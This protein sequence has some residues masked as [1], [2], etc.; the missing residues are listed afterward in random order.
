MIMSPD[1]FIEFGPRA[2]L[3]LIGVITIVGGVWQIDRTW[4]EEGSNAYQRAKARSKDADKVT[5]PEAA[6]IAAFPYPIAFLIG[7]AI[8][9][10]AYLFP[11]RGAYQS[12]CARPRYPLLL[13]LADRAGCFCRLRYGAGRHDDRLCTR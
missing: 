12:G 11:T 7:W 5:V 3:A 8:F 2:I 4:D 6:L 9:A 1:I 13:Q 10:I